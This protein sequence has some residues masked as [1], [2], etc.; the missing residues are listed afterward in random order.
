MVKGT[1]IHTKTIWEKIQNYTLA[2]LEKHF[3]QHGTINV[4]MA[5]HSNNNHDTNEFT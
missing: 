2:K 5:V 4:P 3:C 1:F